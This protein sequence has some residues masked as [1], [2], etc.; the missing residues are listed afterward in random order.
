MRNA[1]RMG[2]ILLL[3]GFVLGGCLGSDS[4]PGGEVKE[5]AG[6]LLD[7]SRMKAEVDSG[8]LTFKMVL[9]RTEERSFHGVLKVNLKD[10]SG[11]SYDRR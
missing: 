4:T 2:W 5:L 6:L 11:E 10:M 3:A 9:Q 1:M 8:R 7:E